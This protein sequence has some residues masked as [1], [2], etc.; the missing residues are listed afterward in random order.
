M[1]LLLAV[2]GSECSGAA[3]DAVAGRPWPEGSVVKIISA[4]ESP[5]VSTPTAWALSQDVY[6]QL[7]QAAV[8]KAKT[9]VR[10]ASDRLRTGRAKRLKILAETV[11]GHAEDVILDEAVRWGAELIVLG[12]HG[13]RKLQRFLLGS[14]SQAVASQAP[15]SVEIVRQ[16]GKTD[17]RSATQRKPQMKTSNRQVKRRLLFFMFFA[18]FCAL[19]Y[20]A[21]AQQDSQSKETVARGKKLFMSYCASC[22]G[23]DGA[24]TGAVAPSLK[25]QPPDLRH[26]QTKQGRFLSEEIAKKIAGDLSPQVHG[27][28]EMPVW[29]LILSSSDISHLVKF[30]ESVQRPLDPRTTE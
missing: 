17:K 19:S 3:V 30:L 8:D 25:K 2:D 27:R 26:I 22:H 16:V 23:V 7:E 18:V 5:V 29:G 6:S 9:A 1:K 10:E 11:S 15:C 13:Y 21:S 20:P 12:S 24:G 4:V 28:G 14:V